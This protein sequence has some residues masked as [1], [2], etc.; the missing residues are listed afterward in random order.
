MNNGAGVSQGGFYRVEEFAIFCF[1][2][3]AKPV[4]IYDDLL[5]VETVTKSTPLWF[6][7]IRYGG[8]N[9]L[10]SKRSGLVY[11]IAIDPASERIVG[12]GRTLTERRDAKEVTGNVDA[13]RPSP[14]E[15]VNGYPVVWPF[16]RSG[17]LS[18][19][20]LKPETLQALATRGLVRVRP[21][22]G[23]P[24][25]NA[26]SISY[27]KSG[28]I[29]KIRRGDIKILGH[30]EKGGALILGDTTR[31]VI[32]KTVWKRT[33]HDA[34]KWGSRVLRDLLGNVVF[35]YPKSPYAVLD[36]LSTVI[37][38]RPDAIVLDFFGGSGT[39][40]NAI[41]LL[42]RAD[43]GSRQCIIVT[44]NEVS[45]KDSR[46]LEQSGIH[47][48]NLE[49]RESGICK[50]VAWPRIKPVLT[51]ERADG[52]RIVG[53]YYTG[54]VSLQEVARS[55]SLLSFADGCGLDLRGRKDVTR[56]IGELR[57]SAAT[58]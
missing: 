49:W 5:S 26:W 47:P 51:G 55:I 50:A 20:Q 22:E 25:G 27:V 57:L 37:S 8:I 10:P 44:N 28:N 31:N 17:T 58:D 11:P 30:E 54:R 42:N 56:L 4:P 52:S 21:Q 46:R 45:E 32:P 3:S 53:D 41:A 48:A 34:G 18:T 14:K 19:W 29:E 40:L 6:S 38:N 12:V 35:D 39:T 24:G 36:T 23:G 13:W 43:G 16:R 15:T 1:F 2:G 33:R 9:A 7:L